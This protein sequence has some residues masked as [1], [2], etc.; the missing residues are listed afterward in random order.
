MQIQVSGQKIALG[1]SLTAY[2][3]ERLTYVVNKHFETA[4]AGHAHFTK[5]G[6]EFVC[7]IILNEGTGRHTTTK[8]D[9]RSEDIYSAFD[10]AL[11]KLEK[12]LRKH[13]SKLKD[14]HNK[15]KVSQISP[16]AMKYILSP[17]R[18]ESDEDFVEGENPIIIAEKKEEVLS[19]SVTDAVAEMDLR[20]LPALMFE[21]SK[22]GK[23]N[24]VYYRKDGN[25]SWVE[26]K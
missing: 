4:T 14:R 20:N 22:T 1:E 7:D 6:Y 15:F 10:G 24:V 9:A 16:D 17:I 5:Q 11:N 25:I 26:S 21:N 23:I 12:Q 3:I 8:S 13:K 18:D 2:V 19:L